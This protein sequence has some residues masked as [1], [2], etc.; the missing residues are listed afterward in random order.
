MAVPEIP[1]L[2]IVVVLETQILVVVAV[3]TTILSLVAITVVSGLLFYYSSVMVIIIITIMAVV[4]E[5]VSLA[6]MATIAANGLS[7]FCLFPASAE[8]TAA[9]NLFYH[10]GGVTTAH[11]LGILPRFYHILN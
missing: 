1:T 2:V 5:M 11:S 4:V 6:V 9:A 7:G 3:E 8:T 10:M